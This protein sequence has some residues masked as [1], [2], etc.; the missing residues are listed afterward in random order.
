LHT[1]ATYHIIYA[2]VLDIRLKDLNFKFSILKYMIKIKVC[3]I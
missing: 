1:I 3:F 2:V